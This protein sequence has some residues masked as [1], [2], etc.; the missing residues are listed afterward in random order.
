MLAGLVEEDLGFAMRDDGCAVKSRFS[1][2]SRSCGDD[3]DSGS[4]L[5]VAILIVGLALDSRR[6][7]TGG[8]GL[9]VETSGAGKI[10][11]SMSSFCFGA[12][13]RSDSLSNDCSIC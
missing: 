11:L 3:E 7:V 13:S 8:E 1:V 9:D 10:L 2:P 4:G 12:L 6:G 5:S